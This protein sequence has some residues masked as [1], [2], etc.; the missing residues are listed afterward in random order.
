MRLSRKEH[1]HTARPHLHTAR[2]RLLKACRWV[3]WHRLGD[4]WTAKKQS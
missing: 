2:P 3:P 4:L 1:L